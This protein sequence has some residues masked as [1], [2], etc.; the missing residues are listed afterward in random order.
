MRLP[1]APQAP[2]LTPRPRP[3]RSKDVATKPFAAAGN[4]MTMNRTYWNR[5]AGR[6]ES[7]IF[8]VLEHD[9]SALIARQIRRYA[10]PARNATDVGCG[11]GHFLPLLSARFRRILA[12]DFSSRCIARARRRHAA[13]PNIDFRT[14]DL[15][16]PGAR[17]P[18]ADFALC[19]N[20]AI[21]PSAAVRGRLFDVVAR[22]LRPGAHL[23]LVVPALES[24]LLTDF[25]LIQ[26]NRRD[27]QSPRRAAGSGFRAHRRAPRPRLHEGV[28]RID[29]VE[30]KHYLKEELQALLGNRGLRTRSVR[31][32]QYPWSSEF[33]DPPRWMQ[34]PYP[35]DWLVVAQK[36]T[37]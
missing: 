16:A 28:V 30:T 8:S 1:C 17:L 24:V 26:W 2:P 37:A 21:S 27:G 18:R 19:V 22:H 20:A 11:I 14:Q 6:Y 15:A 33:T 29:G 25:R 7:E 10:G 5:M 9:R 3:A 36:A 4:G 23:V 12:V 32:I 13:L 35:W 34:S 31:K